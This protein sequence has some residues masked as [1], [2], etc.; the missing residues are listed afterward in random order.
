[1]SFPEVVG[2]EQVVNE[3]ALPH[4]CESELALIAVWAWNDND[5]AR[6]D[7]QW[8][9]FIVGLVSCREVELLGVH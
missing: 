7:Y 5:G 1:L 2:A 3:F 6:K 9:S 8:K 4:N